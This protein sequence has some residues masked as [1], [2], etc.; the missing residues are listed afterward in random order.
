[1][2]ATIDTTDY[3]AIKK[4]VYTLIVIQ[5]CIVTVFGIIL[6]IL[7]REK[8]DMPP[9]AAGKAK[10]RPNVKLDLKELCKDKN[11]IWILVCF[12]FIYGSLAGFGKS[13]SPLYS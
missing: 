10:L 2:F 8:P 11:Y 9:S 13:L 3:A 1:V 12:T 4:G 7:I 5:S 6:V